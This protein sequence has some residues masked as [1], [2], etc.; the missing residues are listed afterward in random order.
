MSTRALLVGAT[1]TIG[2]AVAAA[3]RAEAVE[4]VSAARSGADESVDLSD[5]G[6]IRAMLA[7]VGTVDAIVSCAGAARF[8]PLLDATDEDWSFSLTNKLMGQINLVRF[9]AANVRDGGSITLTTGVLAE[10]PMPGSSIISTVN[11]G[12]QGFVRSAGL[13]LTALRV[14][15]VSPGWVAETLSAMGKDP[16]AGI[17]AAQVAQAY[18]RAMS[19]VVGGEIVPAHP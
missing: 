1:G 14:N 18:V 6:D 12:L 16:S 13:E 7:R 5:P 3:L 2:S 9:G 15:A 8:V 11:A 10:R 4:V 17:P 19:T